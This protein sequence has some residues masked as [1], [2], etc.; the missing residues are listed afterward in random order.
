VITGLGSNLTCKFKTRL[1]RLA[2]GKCSSL[3]D[4]NLCDNVDRFIM[5]TPNFN[6]L[7][8]VWLHLAKY[9]RLILI[10]ERKARAYLISQPYL[11]ILDQ[12]IDI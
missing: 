6:V 9:F 5:L 10:C 12:A 4:L 2:M 11:Q 8:C 7:K 3:F 1:V